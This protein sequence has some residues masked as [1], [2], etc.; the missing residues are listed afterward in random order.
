MASKEEL[1]V[2]IDQT[3]AQIAIETELPARL[4]VDQDEVKELERR[5]D[6]K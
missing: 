1:L 6:D 2:A 4:F 5:T 3:I